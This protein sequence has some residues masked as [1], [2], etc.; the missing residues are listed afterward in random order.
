MTTLAPVTAGLI[1]STLSIIVV[2]LM[3]QHRAPVPPPV[4]VALEE[5]ERVGPV[6]EALLASSDHALR[7]EAEEIGA[8]LRAQEDEK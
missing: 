5:T 8:L 3:T 2:S 4:L 7:P 6:P 1:A